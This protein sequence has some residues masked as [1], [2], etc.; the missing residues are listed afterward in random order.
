MD[1]SEE[2]ELIAKT[3]YGM[4]NILA[5]ELEAIGVKNVK[6]AN[7]GVTFTGTKE[8]L[9]KAN[10][11]LRTAVNILKPIYSFKA[12]NEE[13]LYHKIKEFD[14]SQYFT[15]KQTFAVEPT[16]YSLIFKHSQ[17]AALKTKDAIVDQFRDKTGK[18]PYVDVDSPDILINLHISENNCSLSLNS[19]GEPLFKRGYRIA[20]HEAPLNEVLA[21]GLIKLSGWTP[22]QHFIDPMCGSGT[23][24]IEAALIAKNVPPGIFRKF[25]FERWPDFEPELF[26]KIS[27]DDS[28]DSDEA[29]VCRIIGS[30]ISSRSIGIAR[31]NIKEANLSNYIELQTMDFANF[32]PPVENGV[33]IM[34]PPYGKRI[35]NDDMVN[36]YKSIGDA[37]KSNYNNF[38]AWIISSNL[39]AIKF[40]GL[41]PT[42]KIKLM[43]ASLECTFN[44]YEVYPGSKK[45]KNNEANPDN[46]NVEE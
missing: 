21:A 32:I 27:D 25:G 36:F 40:I 31:N 34:N 33:L 15:L 16:I 13:E 1:K 44:K 18:R 20:N 29:S 5:K 42:K 17:Y 30:D 6:T 28:N 43:N 8:Q 14:W 37:L 10:F 9:Y 3:F 41:H 11:Q 22:N 24:L 39:E 35:Q 45:K 19:S 2:Y 4:E 12:N 23:L 26:A 46:F 38:T 7:R